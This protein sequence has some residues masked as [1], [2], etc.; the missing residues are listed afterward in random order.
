[1]HKYLSVLSHVAPSSRARWTVQTL[2]LDGDKS[3]QFCTM[4]GYIKGQSRAEPQAAQQR[5]RLNGTQLMGGVEGGRTGGDG[6]REGG[7]REC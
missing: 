6:R 7:W 1:M 5:R 4:T 2:D 3:W